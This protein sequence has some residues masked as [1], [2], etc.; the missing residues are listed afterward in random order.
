VAGHDRLDGLDGEAELFG[1]GGLADPTV[2]R[3]IWERAE[4]D[5]PSMQALRATLAA[6]DTTFEET[7]ALFGTVN[8]TPERFYEEGSTF[9]V[10]VPMTRGLKLSEGKQ[11]RRTTAVLD[12]LSTDYYRFR[13]DAD[14]DGR[15]ALKVRVD[16]PDRDTGSAATLVVDRGSGLAVT[17][18]IRLRPDGVGAARVNFTRG[19][20]KAV[21]LVLSNAG[22]ADGQETKIKG[23][24]L[25]IT[26]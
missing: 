8:L 7:Y 24:V 6:R 1:D 11:R 9:A 23:K 20:V 3:H 19:Q 22:R 12:H 5:T 16:M 25:Q 18:P 10:S 26:R 14:L 2:I 13:A 4:G 17:K 15:R 21:Y